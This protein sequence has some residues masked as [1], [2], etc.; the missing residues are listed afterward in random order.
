M[1]PE[2]WQLIKQ[3]YDATLERKPG[4]RAAFLQ[5]ACG[6]DDELRREVESLLA[7]DETG[8][9]FLES[10]ALEIAAKVF[11][12]NWFSRNVG[13]FGRAPRQAP[14]VTTKERVGL[15]VLREESFQSTERFVVQRRLGE[16]GFGVV[17]QV[18]DRKRNTVVALKRLRQIDAPRIYRFKQEFRSLSEVTHRNLVELYEL[19]F[20]QDQWFITM[21][22]IDGPNILDYVR[23]TG[24][25]RNVSS[26]APSSTMTLGPD[27]AAHSDRTAPVEAPSDPVDRSKLAEGT[28]SSLT[29]PGSSISLDRV[30]GAFTQL[31]EGICALHEAKMLHQDLKPSNVLVTSEG[32]VVILDF[33]L[34]TEL[35]PADTQ[36]TIH[37]VVGTPLYMSPEQ[38]EGLRV[39]EASDWYCMGVML[40]EVLTGQ[41]PFTGSLADILASKRCK[42]PPPPADVVPGVPEDLNA[43]CR[44][45]LRRDSKARPS[46]HEVI[47]RLGQVG[48]GIRG[49]LPAATDPPRSGVFVGRQSTLESLWTAFRAVQQGRLMTVRVSGKSGIGK[50]ALV[51]HFIEG[52]QRGEKGTVVL[53][54]QCYERESVPYKAL[55]SWVDALSQYMKRLSPLEAERLMP[56]DV[57]ALARLFPVLHGVEAVANTPRRVQEIPDAQELRRRGFAAL[58]ELLARLTDRKSVVLFIDDLQWGDLD[59]GAMLVELL[60][61]PDPPPL[62]LILCYRAEEAE[63][64]PVLR[65]VQNSSTTGEVCDL[66]V[67][68][69]TPEE[70]I[71]LVTALM[72]RHNLGGEVR[73]KAIVREAH[74]SPF[75]VGELV[76]YAAESQATGELGEISLEQMLLSRIS[77]LPETARRLL[78]V[79]AV[80]GQPIGLEVAG[81][82]AQVGADAQA[83]MSLLRAG[84]LV[85]TRGAADPDQIETY[86]DRIRETV[87]AHLP[88]ETLRN[89][90]LRLARALEGIHD[91]DPEILAVHL[92]A[93]GEKVKAARYT[94][95][96]AEQAAAAL[97]FDHAAELYRLALEL[98]SGEIS[99]TRALRV[100]LG[101]ALVNAGRGAEAAQAFLES[102]EG[103]DSA[104]SLEIRRRA[105]EQL[106]LCGHTD[107]GLEVLRAVLSTV[108]MKLP[109]TQSGVLLSLVAKRAWIRLQGLR[110]HERPASQ[111]P[112]EMLI[113]I[114]TC[115]S[116]ATGLGLVDI[117]RGAEFQARHIL[118]ALKAGEPH[119]VARALAI[120]YAYSGVKPG[121]KNHRRIEKLSQTTSALA[122]RLHDPYVLGTAT[123]FAGIGRQGLGTFR[124]C[125]ELCDRAEAI[126]R[127]Q[128]KGVAWEIGAAQMI[129]CY[130][131]IW[132]GEWKELARRVLTITQEAGTRGDRLLV[133]TLQEREM[134]LVRLFADEPDRAREDS[135]MGLEGWSQSGYHMQHFHNLEA[136]TEI[137]LYTGEALAA[138]RRIQEHW[139][140]FRWSLLD[141]ASQTIVVESR[142]LHARSALAWAAASEGGR[143]SKQQRQLLE[144]ALRDA[145]RIEREKMPWGNA[146]ALLIRASVASI[147]GDR[148]TAIQVLQ[149]A[150]EGLEAVDM[151]GYAAAARRR[152]GELIGG[153]QGKSLVEAADSWM[154]SQGV[155]NPVRMTNMLAPGRWAPST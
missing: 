59:S 90:H 127:E 6:G 44:D 142:H 32:R 116:I 40:Y 62:L 151:A 42:E 11:A 153:D 141:V 60:Q 21:E 91:A 33:G 94:E 34:V 111:I 58:R 14:E 25:S 83:A 80:A 66:P 124:E 89:Y 47:R 103:T 144:Q 133:T 4:Q 53:A 73:A 72:A 115:W 135:Q 105:G 12:R 49:P 5:E 48:S 27:F 147:R 155:K 61:S 88:G 69:L 24:R 84:H 38:S 75:F 39:A 128:C 101:E 3:I 77:R 146:L 10:P 137:D 51:R 106:L 29:V 130:V 30:R 96:A 19:L 97:A 136:S 79:A 145:R 131:L 22:L 8:Q 126:L 93:A 7:E 125:L 74:G 112:T 150:E 107:E 76:R 152:R 134:H 2:R 18:Y 63:S 114:D 117:I 139:S 154:G 23:S 121:R 50:T 87:V 148:D 129:A 123:L 17:Y 78:E 86:H 55:D 41:V 110:F 15:G 68:D 98:H 140:P 36:S 13:E 149:S 56:R 26:D 71:E 20:E 132:L 113:R 70:S 28:L 52:L 138:W 102:V 54:G 143:T 37:S 65:L 1:T 92:Q 81:E 64:N 43:L 57:I 16:G 119:R 122:E 45:L 67:T 118:Y 109:K 9:G 31:A 82:A 35:V 46:G 95:L 99:Q 85:R 120:E 108:G 100:K 104:E